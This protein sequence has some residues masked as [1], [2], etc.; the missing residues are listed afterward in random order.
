MIMNITGDAFGFTREQLASISRRR[1][2]VEARQIAMYITRNL[3]ELSYPEIG[4]A[5]GGRD[6]TTVIY[7]FRKIQ[8][9]ISENQDLF[10]RVQQVQNLINQAR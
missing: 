5:F 9:E 1:A 3:T 7:A 4:K 2:L 6:H 10:N 8:N